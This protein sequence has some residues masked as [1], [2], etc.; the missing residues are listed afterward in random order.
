MAWIEMEGNFSGSSNSS[1]SLYIHNYL[2]D[3]QSVQDAEPIELY[4]F[5]KDDEQYWSYT[6]TDYNIIYNGRNYEAALIQSSDKILNANSLK[7]QIT[8]TIDL[9]NS[10]VRQFIKEPIEGV[11]QLIIYRKYRNDYKIYWRGYVQGVKFS[12]KEAKIIVGLKTNRLRRNGLQRKYQRNC[13]LPLYS[14][15]CTI[16]EDDSNFYVDGTISNIDGTTIIATIFGTKADGWF[17]GGKL[18]TDNGFCKQKIVY[19][20]GTEI[21]ISKSISSLNIGDTFRAWAGCD[22]LKATCKDK[23]DNKLNFGGQPYLPD[24]NPFTGDAVV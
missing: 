16:S 22:H 1:G 9:S 3:E 19:H 20:V 11:I 5:N 23:F 14:Y 8:I 17:V 18:K 13:G 6:S 7:T 12:S 24:K 2:N 4:L 10:F 15:W 21:K